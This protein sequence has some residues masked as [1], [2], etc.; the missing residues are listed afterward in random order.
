MPFG[1]VPGA[2]RATC[3]TARDLVPILLFFLASHPP[4]VTQEGGVLLSAGQSSILPRFFY[5]DSPGAYHTRL[6]TRSSQLWRLHQ[7]P[8]AALRTHRLLGAIAV[9]SKHSD[10]GAQRRDLHGYRV[11]WLLAPAAR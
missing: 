9:M 7:A 8:S 6:V 3:K 11:T 10:G 5:V 4:I 1:I 2:T